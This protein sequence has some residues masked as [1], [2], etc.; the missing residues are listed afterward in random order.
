MIKEVD[1]KKIE[2]SFRAHQVP[3]TMK[4]DE[5]LKLLETWLKS[6]K[7]D[8]LFDKEYKLKA[9]IA[10][11][12]PKGDKRISACP[13]TNPGSSTLIL[14]NLKDYAVEISG[15]G[16]RQKQDMIELGRYIKDVFKLNK[17]NKNFRLFCPDEE[18]SN[19]LYH[20]FYDE[21][22]NFNAKIEE[23]DEFLSKEYI[24]A[25]NLERII[26]EKEN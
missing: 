18:L 2:G 19:R 3:I 9:E 4:K 15:H 20:I 13:Q 6:Y 23:N 26:I 22:R 16:E 10:G 14:P 17:K 25:S 24:L 5:H 8:E 21:N 7:P 11:I 1:G 12:L